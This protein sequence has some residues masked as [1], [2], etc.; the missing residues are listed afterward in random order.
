MNRRQF[1][2]GFLGAAGAITFRSLRTIVIEPRAVATGSYLD[3]RS[4]HD[5]VATARGSETVRVANGSYLDQESFNDPVAT[6]R[7]S[8]TVRVNGARL[9]EH[10]A[11]LAEFGKNPQGG[12]SRLAYSEADARGREY[13]MGLMRAAKLDVNIDAAGNL[14]GRR[15][16]SDYQLKPILFGSHIDSVPEGRNYDRSEEHTSELQSRLHLVCRLLLEKKK[17]N[18]VYTKSIS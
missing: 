8:V 6:A 2:L 18:D 3:Q 15:A 7:G 4:F 12:V 1:N 11:A 17:Q 5:P 16:G 13:V 9:N 10:L 14:I